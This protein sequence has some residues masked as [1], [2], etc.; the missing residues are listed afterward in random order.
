MPRETLFAWTAP[1]SHYPAYANFSRDGDQVVIT[2]RGPADGYQCGHTVEVKVPEDAFREIARLAAWL[3]MSEA[4]RDG[5]EIIVLLKDPSRAHHPHFVSSAVWRDE[6]EGVQKG[7]W[8][9]ACTSYWEPLGWL[10]HPT[11]PTN[12]TDGSRG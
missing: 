4:P 6:D 10:P 7:W 1:G 5:T 3:P 9:D 11:P 8:D 2:A 12:T